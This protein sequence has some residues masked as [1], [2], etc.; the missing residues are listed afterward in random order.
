MCVF[1]FKV[2]FLKTGYSEAINFGPIWSSL[3]F[4][5]KGCLCVPFN[6][7]GVNTV[8]IKCDSDQW[9]GRMKI[10][11]CYL[12]SL[13]L[14]YFCSIFLTTIVNPFLVLYPVLLRLVGT[15]TLPV[16]VGPHRLF[17]SIFSKDYFPSPSSSSH[18]LEFS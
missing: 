12:F 2:A 6:L 5:L 13:Y 15:G 3:A 14:V 4:N 17:L 1:I 11:F 10:P 8:Y 18:S 9:C 16:P 7:K